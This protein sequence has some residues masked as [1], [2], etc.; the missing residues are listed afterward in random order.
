MAEKT[1]EFIDRINNPD[2]YPFIDNL[3]GTISTH[4]MAAEVDE[5]GNWYVFPTIVQL[6]NGELHD[7]K[8]IGAAKSYNLK[9]GNFLPMKS[10]EEALAYAQGGY[11][12]VVG[13]GRG[14]KKRGSK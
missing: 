7:F 9:E 1:P 14:T 4:K 13:S 8:D 10:K 11:K 12:K 6:P 3:D 2:K 5:N